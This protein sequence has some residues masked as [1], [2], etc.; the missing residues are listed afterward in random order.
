MQTDLV[1]PDNVRMAQQLHYPDLA[2]EMGKL[3][4]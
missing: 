1:Q 2:M 4:L 3:D